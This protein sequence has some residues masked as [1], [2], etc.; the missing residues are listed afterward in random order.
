MRIITITAIIFLAPF[1]QAESQNKRYTIENSERL[2]NSGLI[3]WREYGTEAFD[4]ALREKKP[5]FLLLTAPSWCYWC[6]VYT[7]ED[8][9]Y[10]PYLYPFIN[11]RFIPV[12]A[13]ADRR[14]DI[15]R[16]HLEGGWPTTV[17]LAPDGRRLYGYSGVKPVKDILSGLER[18]SSFVKVRNFSAMAPAGY[19]K[20]VSAAPGVRELEK[21][22]QDY[23]EFLVDSYD[24][25]HG[26]FGR[27][28]KFPE[29]LAIN[30]LLDL[31]E[32]GREDIFLQ[33][34]GRTLE[35]Q[36]TE[37][38]KAGTDYRLYDPVEGGFHRYGTSRSWSPP[39][40]EKML[41][42]N[43]RLAMAY[44]RLARLAPGNKRAAEVT[45]KTIAYMIDRW[46]DREKGG[47]SGSTDAHSEGAYYGQRER[48]GGKPGVDRTKYTDWNSEAVIAFLTLYEYTGD[49]KLKEAAERTLGFFVREMVTEQG[50]WHFMAPGGMKSVRGSLADNSWLCAACIRGFEVTGSGAWLKEAVTLAGY[51]LDRLYD[52]RGGGFFERN[53]PDRDLYSRGGNFISGKP[54]EENG[55]MAWAMVK[56]YMITGEAVYLG[57]GIKTLGAKLHEAG[58]L[59]RGYYYAKAARLI[60]RHDLLAVYKRIKNVIDG[61]EDARLK[62]YWL[63]DYLEKH[64]GDMN[65]DPDYADFSPVQATGGQSTVKVIFYSMVSGI[66]SMFSFRSLS[67]ALIFFPLL[68]CSLGMKNS[69]TAAIFLL[70]AA[71]AYSFTGT[72]MMEQGGVMAGSHGGMAKLAGG[73]IMAAAICI[74]ILN[75]KNKSG[76]TIKIHAGISL[77]LG[78]VSG[79]LWGPLQGPV[80]TG[81]I[82]P[83]LAVSATMTGWVILFFNAAGMCLPWSALFIIAGRLINF[84]GAWVSLFVLAAMGIMVFSGLYGELA[85]QVNGGSMI[86]YIFRFEAWFMGLM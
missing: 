28:E 75:G 3:H 86:N 58:F 83:S 46:Y 74:L 57:A 37:I 9:V 27:G 17:I 40:Y 34:A 10:H 26:G 13:D 38:G 24:P 8:Y 32:E 66:L 36:Y 22:L 39:H 77:V 82:L 59:D 72:A 25:V 41:N 64:E 44:G 12:Y 11:S 33:M 43:A 15:A 50:Y 68:L 79:Y 62:N 56:L 69:I 53:S 47:F 80:F 23:R 49:E 61:I 52:W 30:Y 63:D 60:I 51:T 1:L 29:G 45:D 85:S 67:V 54:D 18:A 7:S 16:Q 14:R 65:R 6:H 5:L 31:Y 21:F 70:S 20:T 81:M 84:Q 2:K 35:G 73:I 4:E 78:A 76:P 19:K 71:C 55:I 48:P 42:D